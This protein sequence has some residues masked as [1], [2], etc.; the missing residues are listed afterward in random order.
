V[1]W[2][3]AKLAEVRANLDSADVE[4]ATKA[5][6]ALADLG[7]AEAFHLLFQRAA[8]HSHSFPTLPL[9]RLPDRAAAM[10]EFVELPKARR[11]TLM[12]K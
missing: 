9:M 2:Q 8:K 6:R 11:A 7:T 10:R 5:E 4:A 3:S 1:A 12:D